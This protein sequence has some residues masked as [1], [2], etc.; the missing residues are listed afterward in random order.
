MGKHSRLHRVAKRLHTHAVVFR[1]NSDEEDCAVRAMFGQSTKA[2]ADARGLSEGQVQYRIG[3]AGLAGERQS[4]RS[5]KSSMSKLVYRLGRTAAR[6][7]VRKEIAPK[8]D[9]VQDR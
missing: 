5:G 9:S 7:V 6:N 2:I 4:Y 8:F 3:K 1:E